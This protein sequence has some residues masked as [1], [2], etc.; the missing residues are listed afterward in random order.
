MERVARARNPGGTEQIDTAINVA[1]ADTNP[2][3]KA[4][5]WRIHAETAKE[6]GPRD[7]E[8]IVVLRTAVLSALASEGVSIA[9]VD[10][11]APAGSVIVDDVIATWVSDS[12]REEV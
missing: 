12:L 3:V 10:P 4:M 9:A 6:L 8:R 2:G 11:A 7:A 1:L 5:S